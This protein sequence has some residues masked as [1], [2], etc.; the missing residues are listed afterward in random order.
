MQQQL[1]STWVLDCGVKDNF[2]AWFQ[3]SLADVSMLGWVT[4][5]KA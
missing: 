3:L 2:P 5:H 1:I 4:E